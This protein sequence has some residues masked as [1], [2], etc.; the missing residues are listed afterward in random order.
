[1]T[2]IE[3]SNDAT[4]LFK[5][6]VSFSHFIEVTAANTNQTCSDT[7]IEYCENRALEP[8]AIAKLITPALKGKLQVEL[9]E[10]GLLPEIGTLEGV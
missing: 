4:P 6:A 3:F 7:I 10:L 9:I 5:D 1:M 2:N 8:D